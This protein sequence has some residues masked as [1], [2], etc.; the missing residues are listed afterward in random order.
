MTYQIGMMQGRLSPRRE[1][2][3]LFP[4]TT[5]QVEFERARELG[6]DCIEWLFDGERAEANP[7]CSSEGRNEIRRQITEKNVRVRSLCANYFVAYPFVRVT[8]AERREQS[9]TL[10][11]LITD[12]AEIGIQQL[13][14]P[15]LEN[16]EIKT[17]D[18]ADELLQALALPLETAA[19]KNVTLAVETE[20]PATINIELVTRVAHPNLKICYDIGNAAA[21]GYDVVAEIK[22]IAA[23]LSHIHLKD[24]KR[25]G[26]NVMLGT[27]DVPFGD[28]FRALNNTTF[29]G[30]LVLETTPGDDYH[31]FAQHNIQF[32]RNQLHRLNLNS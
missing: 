2:L 15:V 21:N 16:S 27:G 31:A 1:R 24:R 4:W 3:Q 5:W 10:R 22:Q 12:A 9:H 26:P 17:R 14:L 20:F 7:L 30:M 28:F 23:Y 18:D 13:V 8:A 32:V 11:Q 29:R 6:F 25:G 19:K